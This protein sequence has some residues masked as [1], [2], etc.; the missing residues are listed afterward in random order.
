MSG[1][2]EVLA[3]LSG[4][5]VTSCKPAPPPPPITRVPLAS[6]PEGAR[7]RVHHGT[8][9][10][11]LK[12]SGDSVKALRL[13]CTHFGY[14][15]PLWEEAF[16]SLGFPAVRVVDPNPLMTDLVL[17]EGAPRRH[18]ET[19]VTVEVVSKTPITEAVKGSLGGLLRETSPATAD[20][21][22]SY[23][24]VPDLFHVEIPPSALVR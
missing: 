18:P 13:N 17:R 7:M 9:W 21:L 22:A 11:E 16:D 19:K 20:A 8:V 6:I 24:L 15:R 12:R 4:L 3:G 23:A 5:L 14:A 10:V 2:R 1:R